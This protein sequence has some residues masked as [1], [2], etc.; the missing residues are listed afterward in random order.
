[1]AKEVTIKI[2]GFTYLKKVADPV[3]PDNETQVSAIAWRGETVEVSDADFEKGTALGAFVTGD[4][5]EGGSAP[6]SVVDASDDELD[7]YLEE[8]GPNVG[9]TV[10]LAEGD[11]ESAQR[12]L[13]AENRVTED[14]P[15]QGVVDGLN[16]VIEG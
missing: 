15:R 9:D 13:D 5:G 3:N 1:M 12:L 11:P 14:E 8:E 4:E 2:R 6:F 16:K 7:A 10:A